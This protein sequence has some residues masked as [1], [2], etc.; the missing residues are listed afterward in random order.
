MTSILKCAMQALKWPM[1]QATALGSATW[2]STITPAVSSRAMALD[3][4]WWTAAARALNSGLACCQEVG[5]VMADEGKRF[6]P[7]RHDSLY[8]AS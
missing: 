4:D 7:T 2:K 8:G 3:G 5:P 1:K 6:A